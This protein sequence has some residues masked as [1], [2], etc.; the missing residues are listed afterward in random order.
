[1]GEEKDK[2][3]PTEEEAQLV[4]DVVVLLRSARL[5][6]IEHRHVQESA[7]KALDSVT[8]A[9]ALDPRAVVGIKEGNVL[10]NGKLY[11]G[12]KATI[13]DLQKMLDARQV[14][15]IT[16]ERGI[17]RDEIISL[18][19]TFAGGPKTA[20]DGVSDLPHVSFNKTRFKVVDDEEEELEKAL[21]GLAR[22]PTSRMRGFG[23]GT[24]TGVARGPA[25]GAVAFGGLLELVGKD[26]ARFLKSLVESAGKGLDPSAA[27]PEGLRGASV[28]KLQDVASAYLAD[29]AHDLTD[30]EGFLEGALRQLPSGARG[31]VFESGASAR[32][33]LHSF[34]EQ[35]RAGLLMKELASTVATAAQVRR[36]LDALATEDG[37]VVRLAERMVQQMRS[38]GEAPQEA[39]GKMSRLFSAMKHGLDIRDVTAGIV[40]IADPDSDFGQSLADALGNAGYHAYYN[41]TGSQAWEAV[42]EHNPD[43]VVLEVKLSGIHGL[44]FI[45]QLKREGAKRG[46]VVCTSLSGFE[47]EFEV[48]TYPHH[49]FV[50]KPVEPEVVVDAVRQVTPKRA[51]VSAVSSRDLEQARKIQQNLLPKELPAL[52]LDVAAKCNFAQEVGGDYYDFIP[53]GSGYTGIT[54]GDVSGK[55]VP[56]AMAMVSVRSTL[57]LI[58][59]GNLSPKDTLTHLN[60]LV[61]PDLPRGMF[62]S[63]FYAVVSQEGGAM[64]FSC[65]GHNPV[66]HYQRAKGKCVHIKPNGMAIGLTKRDVFGKKLA[67]A[68]FELAPGDVACLYTD[69]VNEQMNERRQQFGEERMERVIRR[70][71]G[72]SSEQILGSMNAAVELFK[73]S[74]PQHDDSTLIILKQPMG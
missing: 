36:S 57:R 8:R 53:L 14:F 40:V 35:A 61:V 44:T 23:G 65:A 29:P 33:V 21:G 41:A 67:E 7:R 49:A 6:P 34:S 59:P 30:F 52:S 38:S 12:A 62:V 37:E 19:K 16:M 31:K 48:E 10:V 72:A 66:I 20:K 70:A 73:A 45:Q 74:A 17:E 68:S 26:P 60:S 13:A 47:H 1:M 64:K 25:D 2:V 3:A 22:R 11:A 69:G 4:E 63:L 42:R 56:A 27:T 9:L 28:E 71:A 51:G 43:V 15:S 58:A 5:Y 24:R 32:D 18:A 54:I 50:Q 46:V 39:M 55:G